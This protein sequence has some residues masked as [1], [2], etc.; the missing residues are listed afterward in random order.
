MGQTDTFDGFRRLD[1][2]GDMIRQAG[3]D[4]LPRLVCMGRDFLNETELWNVTS[5]DEQSATQTLSAMI[6]GKD[7][8]ILVAEKDGLVIGMVGA[9]IVPFYFNMEHKVAQEFFWFVS[10]EH[11]KGSI[12][13]RLFD[14]LEQ[15][16]RDGG[17]GLMSMAALGCNYGSVSDFYLR[18]GYYQQETTFLRRL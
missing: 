18:R 9:A 11:R 6:D 4:D 15:W 16:A 5:F 7:S 8:V 17:A 2:G 13:V 1:T 14:A 12:G 10:D 3:I